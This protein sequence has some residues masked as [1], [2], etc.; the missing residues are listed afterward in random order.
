MRNLILLLDSLEKLKERDYEKEQQL[1]SELEKLPKESAIEFLIEYARSASERN[2]LIIQ[3]ALVACNTSAEKLL[4]LSS[5]AFPLGE[6]A[7]IR[8]SLPTQKR[9]FQL[10]QRLQNPNH[11]MTPAQHTGHLEI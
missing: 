7:K 8:C 1:F 3:H 10:L 5:E 2:F 6:I 4:L 11:Q 9:Q